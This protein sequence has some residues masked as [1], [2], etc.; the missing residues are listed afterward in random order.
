M[1]LLGKMVDYFW[2]MIFDFMIEEREY[3][4]EFPEEIDEVELS[5]ESFYTD[6]EFMEIETPLLLQ[7][8]EWNYF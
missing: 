3:E 1:E 7:Y 5:P 4:E 6:G 8:E 2:D